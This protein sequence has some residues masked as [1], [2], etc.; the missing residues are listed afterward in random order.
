MKANHFPDQH[1]WARRAFLQAGAASALTLPE[2][3]QA[4]ASSTGS[5]LHGSAKACILLF[6]TGGPAQQETFDP[7]PDAPEGTR[8]EFRPIATSVNGIQ[9]SEHLP[10]L[11]KLT[12]HCALL[13]SV[14]HGSDTHGVGVHYNLTGLKHAPRRS[15]EPQLDRQD[16]PSIGA[17]MRYLRGDRKGLPAAVQLPRPVGDQNNA[18]W[19]GQH[20]GVMGPKYDP[21]F[22]FDEKWMPG[23]PL[24]GFAPAVDVDGLRQKGR[25]NLLGSIQ[26]KRTDRAEVERDYARFQRMALDVLDSERSWRAFKL[27]DEKPETLEL[28]GNNRFGRSCLVARRLIEAGVALVTVP[29]HFKQSEQNFDT[30]NKHFPKMKN[31]LLPVVDQ[32]FSALLQDLQD[33]GILGETLVAW[34]GE[35]GRTPK[36]NGNGGRDHWGRVYSAV[37]AGGGVRGGRV[38]G[39]TDKQGGLPVDSPIHVT[40]L[41][42]TMYKALGV[43]SDT[44]VHDQ[45]G[46]PLFVVHGKP[47]AG[48]L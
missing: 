12:H 41:F 45:T 33:R 4:R 31:M 24:P 37:L 47:V 6:M 19:A 15:G 44:P 3:L 18:M 48:V 13:R 42:A 16:P 39:R 43:G 7:K 1:L 2:L 11:A 5:S 14:Y 28:Y 34:T 32:A 23:D 36:I 35:F 46:R 9:I 40:D 29:W 27:D 17:V 8:G 20:A 22:L 10:K 21:L 26:D 30:H 25:I 38:V